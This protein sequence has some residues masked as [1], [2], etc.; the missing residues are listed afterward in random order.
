MRWRWRTSRTPSTASCV[1]GD[2]VTSFDGDEMPVHLYWEPCDVKNYPG[3]WVVSEGRRAVDPRDHVHHAF[4]H[5][6]H[7][8]HALQFCDVQRRD[9]LASG[10]TSREKYDEKIHTASAVA[11]CANITSG[12]PLNTW[13]ALSSD[14]L[15]GG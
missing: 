6:D 4:D 13:G 7:V 12:S 2:D 8:H 11:A 5:H 1:G 14:P 9:C 10:L 3:A 15:F